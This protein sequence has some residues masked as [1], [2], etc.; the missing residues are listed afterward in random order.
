MTDKELAIELGNYINRQLTRIAAL[1]SI[2]KENQIPHW[3]EDAARIAHE[4][5]SLAVS[6]AH[7]HHLQYAIG[8][9]TPE[10]GLIRALYRHFVE[11][12]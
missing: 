9:D 12:R 11:G 1:E 5:L 7:R 6:D 2:L 3:E 10:S 8:D 4:P